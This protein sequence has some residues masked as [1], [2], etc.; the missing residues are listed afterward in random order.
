MLDGGQSIT[1]TPG[2]ARLEDLARSLVAM[3]LADSEFQSWV[4]ETRPMAASFPL[5]L[6]DR[7]EPAAERQS[8]RL[9]SEGER[10]A[11]EKKGE[12]KWNVNCFLPK[13]TAQMSMH[14]L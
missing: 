12:N 8:R 1:L 7:T 3:R 13:F 14:L 2:E 9:P 11:P 10:L 5:F 4:G 6:A